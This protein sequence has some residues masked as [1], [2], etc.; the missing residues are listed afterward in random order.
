M[1][2]KT[3]LAIRYF[4]AVPILIL[5]SV[6]ALFIVFEF[7]LV[8][9]IREKL[10]TVDEHNPIAFGEMLFETRGCIGCH[11]LEEGKESIGP[12]L[13]DIANRE[14]QEYLKNSIQYPDQTIADGFREGI[15]PD[16]GK[17]LDKDQI[18]ALVK[19]LSGVTQK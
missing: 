8:A 5:I 13:F 12:N 7:T 14:S 15:M 10:Q 19:Y 16:Y 1:E 3:K 11:S 6:F 9:D 18:D 4:F 17:I 2:N